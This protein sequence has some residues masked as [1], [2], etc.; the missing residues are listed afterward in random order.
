MPPYCKQTSQGRNVLPFS[1][2]STV[3]TDFA[4]PVLHTLFCPAVPAHCGLLQ[5]WKQELLSQHADETHMA[6]THL[7]GDG[8]SKEA[9]SNLHPGEKNQCLNCLRVA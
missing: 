4:G 5:L 1:S 2:S 8:Q 9:G 7:W 3:F 6:F